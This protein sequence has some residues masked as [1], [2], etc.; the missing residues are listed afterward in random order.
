MDQLKLISVALLLFASNAGANEASTTSLINKCLNLKNV[1]SGPFDESALEGTRVQSS[2]GQ[3]SGA[4]KASLYYQNFENSF[5]GVC[6]NA[7]FSIEKNGLKGIQNNQQYIFVWSS[8]FDAE[9]SEVSIE[10]IEFTLEQPESI[11]D[12]LQ[13][14]I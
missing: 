10:N 2:N 5:K 1:L 13:K 14:E 11:S 6:S 3:I 4:N 8:E 9:D 12:W 7:Q